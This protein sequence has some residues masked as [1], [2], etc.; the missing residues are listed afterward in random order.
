MADSVA[1]VDAQAG[2]AAQTA[3]DLFAGAVGGVAQVLL[4]ELLLIPGSIGE[5]ELRDGNWWTSVWLV[6]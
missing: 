5:R 3:K 4:G 2:G 1:D 6:S